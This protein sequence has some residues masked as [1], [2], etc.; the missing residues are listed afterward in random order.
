[1]SIYIYIYVLYIVEGWKSRVDIVYIVNKEWWKEMERKRV[2]D[3]WRIVYIYMYTRIPVVRKYICI[4]NINCSY[5]YKAIWLLY[6][7]YMTSVIV[8]VSNMY[9]YN[10]VLILFIYII[11]YDLYIIYIYL[12]D[13]IGFAFLYLLFIKCIKN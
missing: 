4:Q 10:V 3:Y 7:C 2:L 1:M 11:S 12:Y 5:I 6:G 8:N 9:I 13:E